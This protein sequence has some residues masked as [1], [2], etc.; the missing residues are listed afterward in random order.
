MNITRTPHYIELRSS[1]ILDDFCIRIQKDCSQLQ[2]ES[3]GDEA[4]LNVNQLISIRDCVNEVIQEH[5]TKVYSKQTDGTSDA[6]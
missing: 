4:D 2:I 6:G 1:D 5:L 3:N